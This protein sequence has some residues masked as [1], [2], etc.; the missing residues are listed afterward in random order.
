MNVNIWQKKILLDKLD[1]LLLRRKK[2][3][4]KASSTS[5]KEGFRQKYKKRALHMRITWWVRFRQDSPAL[6]KLRAP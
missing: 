2:N 5:V 1:V 3:N 6:R 4:Q